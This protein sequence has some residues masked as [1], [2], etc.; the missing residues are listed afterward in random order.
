M[1]ARGDWVL[2]VHGELGGGGWIDC[3][4]DVGDSG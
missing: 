4:S 3:S 1:E 2:D